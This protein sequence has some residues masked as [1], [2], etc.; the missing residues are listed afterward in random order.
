MATEGSD[1][2]KERRKKHEG[3][4]AAKCV[5]AWCTNSK[6]YM[7]GEGGGAAFRNHGVIL[8]SRDGLPAHCPLKVAVIINDELAESLLNKR[9]SAS[10][11][12]FVGILELLDS[13]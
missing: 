12:E 3:F 8:D 9:V 7:Q 11:Q 1:K 6:V 4:S 13:I 2:E 5:F 10:L